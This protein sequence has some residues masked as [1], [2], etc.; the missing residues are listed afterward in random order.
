[1]VET[2]QEGIWILDRDGRTNYVNR[3]MARLLGY[4]EE[5][6]IGRFMYEFM[7][8]EA[9][10]AAAGATESDGERERTLQDEPHRRAA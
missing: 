9:V 10:A 2:A 4:S 8:P 1:M 5:E 6:M 7:D 3:Q